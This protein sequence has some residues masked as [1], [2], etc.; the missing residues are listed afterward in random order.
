MQLVVGNDIALRSFD[1]SFSAGKI[2]EAP[3]SWGDLRVQPLEPVRFD[4]DFTRAD[5]K[6]DDLWK[7]TGKW[8]LSAS[9]E[10]ISDRNASMSSNPFAFQVTSPGAESIATTGRWFWDSYDAR[11]A[12]RPGAAGQVGI[13]A[14]VKDTKNYLA[15]RWS[16]EEGDNARQL[17]RVT[18]GKTTVLASGKGAF[19]P[20]Q[21]YKIGIRTSPGYIEA[22]I[23]GVPVLRA[24]NEALGQ[25]GVGLLAGDI[26]RRRVR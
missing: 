12:V 6:G 25:G 14:Y 10:H 16:S 8:E 9:S 5:K 7:T 1:A 21:W 11:V 2:S 23:D 17:V 4:D 22:I 3:A 19:L 24:A 13:A 20:K 26:R 18:D 15:F